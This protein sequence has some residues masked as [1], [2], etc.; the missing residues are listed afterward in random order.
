[1]LMNMEIHIIISHT[2]VVDGIHIGDVKPYPLSD[3]VTPI[4]CPSFRLN[5]VIT[6]IALSNR[7]VSL[8]G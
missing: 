8:T 6:T 2:Q 3:I 4:V 1:M 7:H 5:V